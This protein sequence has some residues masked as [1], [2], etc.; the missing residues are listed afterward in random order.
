MSSHVQMAVRT[1]RIRILLISLL[2]RIIRY[3]VTSEEFLWPSAFP[4]SYECP[5]LIRWFKEKIMFL[6]RYPLCLYTPSHI[7]L[8]GIGYGSY[9]FQN[10][11]FNNSVMLTAEHCPNWETWLRKKTRICKG[12]TQQENDAARRAYDTSYTI[13]SPFLSLRSR[14]PI[15]VPTS[16]L[17]PQFS[18]PPPIN[19]VPSLLVGL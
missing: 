7:A 12:W 17:R 1:I 10:S 19:S 4:F 6:P 9:F 13:R 11:R 5:R 3:V 2:R 18:L 16:L 15:S 8:R 14:K